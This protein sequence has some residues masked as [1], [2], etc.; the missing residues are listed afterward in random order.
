MAEMHLGS[1]NMMTI[2]GAK[3]PFGRGRQKCSLAPD[4]VAADHQESSRLG[5]GGVSLPW[6][7]YRQLFVAIALIVAALDLGRWLLQRFWSSDFAPSVLA[8]PLTYSGSI[9]QAVTLAL[10]QGGLVAAAAVWFVHLSVGRYLY[11][12]LDANRRSKR[13]DIVHVAPLD[14]P[15]S[16][17]GDLLLAQEKLHF[18]L[19]DHQIRLDQRLR[20]AELN[21]IRAAKLT[22]TGE[23]TSTI[24]HDLRSP[25]ASILGHA[26]FLQEHGHNTPSTYLACLE[27]ILRAAHHI[28]ELV[29]RMSMFARHSGD[30]VEEVDLAGCVSD[31][32]MFLEHHFRIHGVQF[33]FHLANQRVVCFGNKQMIVQ[34]LV[35]L[36]SN[37]VDAM[38]ELGRDRPRHLTV[39]VTTDADTSVVTV[40]DSG[41][42]V[43]EDVMPKIFQPFFTTKP[44]GKG[45]GL[46]LASCRDIATFLGA[47]LD[48]GNR[49]EGGA[50]FRLVLQAQQRQPT[51]S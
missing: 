44:E 11:T 26:Q 42:G 22:T 47:R 31:A 14:L 28:D 43:P 45:T 18:D 49:P 50:W 29:K 46:G 5:L 16:E 41:P 23:L 36:C 40:E 27:K 30:L 33:A 38:T 24:V 20:E 34:I 25:L 35:N 8:S 7:L 51:A 9:T 37:A 48:V 1:Q 2:L 15:G 13:N 6:R 32:A 17:I 10:V 39:R 3:L 21:L 19:E 12:L 4:R